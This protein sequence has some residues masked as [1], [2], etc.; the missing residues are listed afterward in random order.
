MPQFTKFALL[1]AA[2]GHDA[3]H[4]GHTNG[5]ET[6]IQSDRW[7]Q[8]D[9]KSILEKYHISV[10]RKVIETQD[11]CNIISQF[12]S[13]KKK[14]FWDLVETSILGTDMAVHNDIV[15]EIQSWA[16]GEVTLDFQ[17]MEDQIK[18]CRA[19]L[20]CADLSNPV[21]DFKCSRF[22]SERI[23]SEFRKQVDMEKSHGFTPDSFMIQDTILSQCKSEIGFITYVGK[24]LWSA[25]GSLYPSVAMLARQLDDNIK[26]YEDLVKDIENSNKIVTVVREREK[27][28]SIISNL[29]NESSENCEIDRKIRGGGGG[30]IAPQEN[31]G[32]SPRS[33][34]SKLTKVMPSV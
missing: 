19:L 18:L 16:N 8:A 14:E 34:L 29:S 5:F 28:S 1:V 4:P 24:P 17:K 2:L 7:K 33:F 15:E 12:S 20:H 25:L 10:L 13:A 31:K 32:D 3:G 23:A 11:G 6:K 27:P 22:W 26:Q 30:N 21:R 9:G